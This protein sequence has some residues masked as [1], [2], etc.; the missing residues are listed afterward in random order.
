M[1]SWESRRGASSLRLPL[2]P[3]PFLDVLGPIEDLPH[4]ADLL[5]GTAT[6]F[7]H[8]APPD[9]RPVPSV[10]DEHRNVRM[11]HNLGGHAAHN[12]SRN[13]AATMRRHDYQVA[14][15][16]LCGIDDSLMRVILLD[17]QGFARHASRL[18]GA[19]DV[20][21]DLGSVRLGVSGIVFKYLVYLVLLRMGQIEYVER[22]FNSDRRHLGPDRL[23]K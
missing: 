15:F 19:G 2:H 22:W 17:L 21:K 20:V 23:C 7:L 4:V 8:Q 5:L 10:T 11:G 13:A 1:S 14:A 18:R 6:L 9:H 16:G 12:D 3:E